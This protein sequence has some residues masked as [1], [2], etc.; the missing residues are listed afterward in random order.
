[1]IPDTTNNSRQAA[2]EAAMNVLNSGDWTTGAI[3]E[4]GSAREAT[5][6]YGGIQLDRDIA[7]WVAQ[8]A[9]ERG[10][11]PADVI[12]DLVQAAYANDTDEPVLVRPSQ[13]HAALDQVLGGRAA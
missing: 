2:I 6:T 13:L 12:R 9:D 1:M 3:I 4:H 5:V 10:A 7:C 8:K 11:T